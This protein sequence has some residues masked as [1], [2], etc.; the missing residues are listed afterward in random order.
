MKPS[1]YR[2][3]VEGELG[4]RYAAAFTSMQLDAHDGTTEILGPIKDDAELRGLLDTLTALGLSLVS[5]T[6]IDV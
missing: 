6:P 3:V 2:I 4:P 5:V 1:D